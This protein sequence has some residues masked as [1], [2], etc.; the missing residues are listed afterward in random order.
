MNEEGDSKVNGSFPIF[1]FS[2]TGNTWWITQQITEA[3]RAEGLDA[4]AYSI[5][6]TEPQAAAKLMEA[7]AGRRVRFSHLRLGRAAYFYGLA[8]A[9]AGFKRKESYPGLRYA[10]PMVGNRL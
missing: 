1:F 8:G 4:Q 9:A 3:L 10:G 2:G 6:Q 5:E 7:A